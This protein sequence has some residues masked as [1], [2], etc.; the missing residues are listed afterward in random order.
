ME[1]STENEFEFLLL[2]VTLE[3]VVRI[4]YII[5]R[6][7]LGWMYKQAIHI[8]LENGLKTAVVCVCVCAVCVPVLFR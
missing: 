8:F 3:T 6:M 7:L 4:K 1:P 5:I 2:L